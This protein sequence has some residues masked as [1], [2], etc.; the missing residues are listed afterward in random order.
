MPTSYIHDQ[1]AIRSNLSF[2]TLGNC[3]VREQRLGDYEDDSLDCTIA[4]IIISSHAQQN[5]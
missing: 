3:L 1:T 2:I 5:N 4:L